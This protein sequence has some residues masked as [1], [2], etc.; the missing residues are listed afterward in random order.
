[1]SLKTIEHTVSCSTPFSQHEGVSLIQKGACCCQAP[2]ALCRVHPARAEGPG[3]SPAGQLLNE[4]VGVGG[5]GRLH[6]LHRSRA[7]GNLRAP[8]LARACRPAPGQRERSVGTLRLSL[9]DFLLTS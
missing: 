7:R 9:A 8:Q 1:M 6:H 4:G 3:S 5:H 2:V